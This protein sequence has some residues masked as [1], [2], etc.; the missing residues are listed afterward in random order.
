[1]QSYRIT[2]ILRFRR[3]RT[4]GHSDVLGFDAKLWGMF[5]LG[6]LRDLEIIENW[7][8][9][10][11]TLNRSITVTY[12]KTFKTLA[13]FVPVTFHQSLTKRYIFERSAMRL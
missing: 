8:E 3:N 1:M 4:R 9:T 2:K 7:N 6:S 11:T 12:Y 10:K 5:I 13:I